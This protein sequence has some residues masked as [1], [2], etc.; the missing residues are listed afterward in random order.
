MAPTPTDGVDAAVGCDILCPAPP[1]WPVFVS[2]VAPSTPGECRPQRTGSL[3][4]VRLAPLY[5]CT[6]APTDAWHV[7]GQGFL[8]LE[9]RV[10]GRVAGRLRAANFPRERPDRTTVPDFRG[11]IE[12]DDGATV[13]FTWQ[14]YGRVAED[15]SRRLVGSMTHL[16]DDERYRWLNDAVCVLAGE[17]RPREDGHFD[18]VLEVCELAWEPP[19]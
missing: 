5:T 2:R 17:V 13:L 6:F 3:V 7:E 4:A 8:L 18:V 12:T 1:T 11:V 9:G 15:G 14:G 19:A 16:A 10:E